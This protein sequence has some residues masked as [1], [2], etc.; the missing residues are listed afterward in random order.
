MQNADTIIKV[1]TTRVR[2][3][4][5]KVTEL[6]NEN[7]ELYAMVDQRDKQINVL[8]ERITQLEQQYKTMTMAKMLTL[9]DGDI[10]NTKRKVNKL[11]ATVDKCITLMGNAQKAE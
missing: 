11:I 8:N 4:I 10:E 3:L 2:Q 5:L 9:T 7:A 1:F 6:K